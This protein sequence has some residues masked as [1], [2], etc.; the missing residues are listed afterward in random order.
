MGLV[1]YNKR[2]LNLTVGT[3]GSTHD[4]RFLRN[5]GLFKQILNEEGL[6]DETVDLG[7]EYCKIPLVT[8]GD[9]AF[10]R[11]SWLLTNFNCDT[12]D[13]WKRYYNI[14]MNSARV[15]TENCYGML[16]SR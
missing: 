9:S 13:E 4:A 3:P 11:F 6:S 10:P 2:F 16:K 12:N 5:T 7:D 14:K 8:V 15:V 1:G